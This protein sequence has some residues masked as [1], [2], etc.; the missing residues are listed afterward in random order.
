[1][2]KIIVRRLSHVPEHIGLMSNFRSNGFRKGMST[3]VV[4]VRITNEVERH[5]NKGAD[6]NNLSFY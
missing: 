1:M 2:G 5:E 4:L 6:R 3:V